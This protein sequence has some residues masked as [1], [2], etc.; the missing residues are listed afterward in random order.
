M[1]AILQCISQH[2]RF[3]YSEHT[4]RCPPLLYNCTAHDFSL[5]HIPM[6]FRGLQRLTPL[7]ALSACRFRSLAGRMFASLDH[8]RC[9]SSIDYSPFLKIDHFR[10][11]R[12]ISSPENPYDALSRHMIAKACTWMMH[13]ARDGTLSLHLL[14]LPLRCPDFIS[15]SLVRHPLTSCRKGWLRICGRRLSPQ[16]DAVFHL[17]HLRPPPKANRFSSP[18]SY[19]L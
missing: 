9:F 14:I 7:S 11:W 18:T 1:H 13:K 16:Y 3:V 17:Q 4:C 10:R 6:S 15:V 2:F 5:A 12:I 19:H 8:H